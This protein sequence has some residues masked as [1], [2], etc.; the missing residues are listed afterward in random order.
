MSIAINYKSSLIKP[1]SSS[2][3]LFVDEMFKISSLKK[4]IKSAEYF[5]ISDLIKSKDLKK[6]YLLLT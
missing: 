1:K 2:L 3:V 4:H 6:K 5:F